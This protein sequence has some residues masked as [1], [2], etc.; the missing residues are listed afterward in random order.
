MLKQKIIGS[1]YYLLARNDDSTTMLYLRAMHAHIIIIC[2]F[3]YIDKATDIIN[4]NYRSVS[5]IFRM[6]PEA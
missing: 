2:L 5:L 6:S 4:H 1:K 3:S